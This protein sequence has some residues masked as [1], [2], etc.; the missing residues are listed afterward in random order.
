MMRHLRKHLYLYV[1]STLFILSIIL[2][3]WKVN[4]ALSIVIMTLL[5]ILSGFHIFKK[6]IIDLKYLY[7]GID[8]LVTVAVIAAYII[9]DYFEAAA[10]TYLFTL[11]HHLEKLSLEK[12]RSALTKM[13]DL[14]PKF[15]RK[16]IDDQEVFIPFKDLVVG[17]TYLVKSGEVIPTDGILLDGE[18]F[19]DEQ[20]MTGES[21]PLL[22]QIGDILIGSTILH[23][24]Y[25]YMQSTKVGEDT[26]LSKMISMVEDAQDRKSTS[27]KFIEK[28]ARYY[29]PLMLL[30][31]VL[32][33]FVSLDIRLA[34]TILVISCPGALVISTPVS[35]V[36]GIGNAARKGI[37]FKGGESI[38][39]LSKGQM[40][41][42]DK[43][44]TLTK[45]NLEIGSIKTYDIDENELIRIAAIGEKL[46]EHPIAKA[47]TNAAELR[48]IYYQEPL[49]NFKIDIGEGI[50]YMYKGITYHIG[51][52]PKVKHLESGLY[53][54]DLTLIK[55]QGE[56]TLTL[57]TNE[58]IL[59]IIGVKDQLRTHSK[60]LIV[61]LKKM[62]LNPLVMLTGDHEVVAKNVSLSVGLD[63][64]HHS[65][66]PV[67]KSDIL[68]TYQETYQ[69]IFVGDGLND[70]IALS[71]ADASIAI[72]GLGKDLAMETADV[73]ILSDDIRSVKDAI[74]IS[75]KVKTTMY[76]NIGFA[77]STV[78]I[79]MIGVI[80]KV[81]N[82]SMGMLIHEL[83]VIVVV[84]NAIRLLRYDLKKR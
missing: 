77:L 1:I 62:N 81:V 5:T 20:M 38:E 16:I 32:V 55:N 39:R 22:K 73:V 54:N 35:Y 40:V 19:V 4:I 17:D 78:A 30:L 43:T 10:V 68:K 33:Y 66:S 24:G 67:D 31:S 2:N 13:M 65:L 79:L 83:S 56:T 48:N 63:K 41:S 28:F 64:F 69:T 70:S 27:E 36:A 12:T 58:K 76:Q 9:G 25:I 60:E 44:G 8:L 11:G 80:F 46:S 59:G 72:S 42:F 53:L 14:K 57:S 29:T 51:K 49:D 82:M 26:T 15:A 23:S 74:L 34:I 61:E 37:L 3:E 75:R 45:G 47:I 18:G 71:Y 6:A 50:S 21:I 84:L 7:I 52:S